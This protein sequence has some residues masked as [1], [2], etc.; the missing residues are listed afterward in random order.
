MDIILEDDEEGKKGD[1]WKFV[2]QT[3]EEPTKK[4]LKIQ[5]TLS[6]TCYP[7]ITTDPLRT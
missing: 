7:S 5:H 2:L 4:G 6:Q 1:K 3:D